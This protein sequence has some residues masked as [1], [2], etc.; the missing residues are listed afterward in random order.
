VE[1]ARLTVN[2]RDSAIS[3]RRNRRVL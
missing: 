1:E 3:P 2:G